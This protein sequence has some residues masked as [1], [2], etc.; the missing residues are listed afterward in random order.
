LALA[1]LLLL[2]R[3]IGALVVLALPPAHLV[4][5]SWLILVT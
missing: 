5:G 3:L 4:S 2:V 1:G